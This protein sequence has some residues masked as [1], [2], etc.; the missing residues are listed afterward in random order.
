MTQR[1]T[2]SE[3]YLSG[4]NIV[5]EEYS[6]VLHGRL[7]HQKMRP[8]WPERQILNIGFDVV[9]VVALEQYIPQN[10]NIDPSQA[11]P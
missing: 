3:M 11:N 8:L 9:G 5:E 7:P 4:W 1:V 10:W 2:L 6:Q